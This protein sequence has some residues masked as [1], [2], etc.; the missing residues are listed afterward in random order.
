MYISKDIARDPRTDFFNMAGEHLAL[1]M[2]DKNADTIPNLPA[3][4]PIMRKLAEKL[5]K[6]IPF[7]RV[8]FY[9][10]EGKIY[11]GEL[12]FYHA[13]GYAPLWPTCWKDT[14]GSYICLPAK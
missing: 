9:I 5:S 8:D 2:L 10:V 3:Q 1:R 11:F 7:V 14:L 4:F 12:T 6:D 13:S